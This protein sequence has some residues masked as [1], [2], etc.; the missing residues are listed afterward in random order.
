[1]GLPL[2]AVMVI[3]S[4]LDRWITLQMEEILASPEGIGPLLWVH[5]FFSL[6]VNLVFPLSAVLLILSTFQKEPAWI[7]FKRFFGQNL[8][9][10]MRS[11]GSAMLWSLVFIFPGL[12]R[13]I[14]YLLVPFIV[15]FD[16]GYQRGEKD[17]LKSARSRSRGQMLKLS[18]IF[19]L[20]SVALPLFMT[21]FDEW[22][23]VWRTP[24]PALLIC[25][26]EM[27]FNICFILMLWMVFQRSLSNEPDVPVERS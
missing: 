20:F 11:W 22:K 10:I 15:C 8:I 13:W 27:L 16:P 19:L 14:Q 4:S 21:G 24:L 5:G 7:F 6:A 17:A 18:G 1:M 2:F 26:V 12:I 25:F 23:V 3:G 9:E